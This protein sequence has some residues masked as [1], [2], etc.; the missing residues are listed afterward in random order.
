VQQTIY[1]LFDAGYLS[2]QAAEP[3]RLA[4]VHDALRLVELL[5]HYPPARTPTT[6]A[7][8]ALLY[9]TAAR[10]PARRSDA[11]KLIGLEQQD[12]A[13]WDS[14]WIARG[15]EWLAQS[16]AGDH[17]S[18]YHIEAA[19]AS[20][21]AQAPSFA[22]TDWAAI[23]QHYDAL[24]QRFPTPAVAVSRAIAIRYAAGPAEAWQAFERLNADRGFENSVLYLAGR[25]ELLYAL[26]AVDE[27][28]QALASAVAAAGNTQVQALLRERQETWALARE[29]LSPR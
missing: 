3:V 5:L 11:G 16:I 26:G 15:F 23:V 24:M 14:R 22:A 19:I 2:T 18:R 4:L 27:A 21:H 28:Q 13:R 1:L 25:A 20:A 7:L 17:L 8:A 9:L 6:A 29:V 12:R 10:L